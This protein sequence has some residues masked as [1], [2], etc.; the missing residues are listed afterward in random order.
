MDNHDLEAIYN[1]I[2][3]RKQVLSDR[4]SLERLAELKTISIVIEMIENGNK[5]FTATDPFWDKA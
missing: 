2:K 3:A 5:P 4:R 1:W